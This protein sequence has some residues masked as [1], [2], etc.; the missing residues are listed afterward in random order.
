MKRYNIL[1]PLLFLMAGCTKYIPVPVEDGRPRLLIECFPVSRTDSTLIKVRHAAPTNDYAGYQD[2]VENVHIEFKVNDKSYDVK[3]LRNREYLYYVKAPIHPGDR[4]SLR[5]VADDYPD[6]VAT[7][8]IPDE[9]DLEVRTEDNVVYGKPY[10]KYIFSRKKGAEKKDGFYAYELK[11]EETFR[12]VYEDDTPSREE[13]HPFNW[14]REDVI[15][16]L[17]IFQA[18]DNI[19][20]YKYFFDHELYGR[21]LVMLEDDGSSDDSVFSVN[22]RQYRDTVVH[23]SPYESRQYEIHKSRA[24]RITLY[25]VDKQTYRYINPLVHEG[26]GQTG[27]FSPFLHKGNVS[28]GY[29]VLGGIT[30]SVEIR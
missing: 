26:M 19:L 28:G 1:I 16:S 25:K 10:K 4:I 8:V 2:D 24:Y 22:I 17:N 15:T 5:A 30:E 29:G 13:S 6:A 23:S 7:T 12:Y 21:K 20:G 3:K 14:R 11:T 18:P 9:F 27:F